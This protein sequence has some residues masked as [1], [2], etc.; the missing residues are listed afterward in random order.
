VFHIFGPGHV[1]QAHMTNA[2]KLGPAG[3]LTYPADV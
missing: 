3:T 1:E 2:A